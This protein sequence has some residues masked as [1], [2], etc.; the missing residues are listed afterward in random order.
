MPAFVLVDMEIHDEPGYAP[1]RPLV[2][3]LIREHQGKLT[4]R[5]SDFES[6]EGD[7]C[8]T[9]MV[10][11]EFPDRTHAKAFVDDPAYVPVKRIRLDTA[12]S[13]FV[14]GESE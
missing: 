14:I 6:V 1:Y 8:P 13:K 5:I 3:D 2:A 9:R 4:H 10:I 7:W 12:T 11:I